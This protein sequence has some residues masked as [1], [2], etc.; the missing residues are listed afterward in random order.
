MPFN[1]EELLQ[2]KQRLFSMQQFL[3]PA[4]FFAAPKS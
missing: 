4:F 3:S 1:C 2:K